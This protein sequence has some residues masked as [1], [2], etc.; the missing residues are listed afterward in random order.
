MWHMYTCAHAISCVCLCVCVCV[1]IHICLV[2]YTY[3]QNFVFS[4]IEVF[5]FNKQHIGNPQ[6]HANIRAKIRKLN[7]CYFRWSFVYFRCQNLQKSEWKVQ[8][9]K[10][11]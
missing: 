10:S 11:S 8:T 9:Q 3:E 6:C 7:S 4:P 1:H 2:N 5:N